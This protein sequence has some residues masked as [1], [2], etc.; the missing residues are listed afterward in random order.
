MPG[1]VQDEKMML[2]ALV[3]LCLSAIILLKRWMSGGNLNE[4]VKI[5]DLVQVVTLLGYL[6]V[7]ALVKMKADTTNTLVV[8]ERK[9]RDHSGFLFSRVCIRIMAF[10]ITF[11]CVLGCDRFEYEDHP[12]VKRTALQATL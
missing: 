6:L 12:W 3:L 9:V 2:C 10:G 8:E 5:H 4:S 7:L 11:F 1:S